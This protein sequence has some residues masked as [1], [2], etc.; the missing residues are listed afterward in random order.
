M[1]NEKILGLAGVCTVLFVLIGAFLFF[2]YSTSYQIQEELD[3][4]VSGSNNCLRFLSRTVETVYVPLTTGANERWEL[5]IECTD[6][7]TANGWVDLYIYNGYWDEGADN[8]C[9]SE[10]IY[11][12]IDGIVS[13]DYELSENNP[14][15]QTFGTTIQDSHTLFFI[16][17]P[18]GPSAFHVTLNQ[19]A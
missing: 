11:S 12:I 16:L 2:F 1:V 13:L 3:F 5:T 19:K 7:A 15:S 10:D 8:K 6:I 14:Y 9:F 17:P 18:G 4:V